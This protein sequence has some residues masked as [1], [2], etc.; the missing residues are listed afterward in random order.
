M[1]YYNLILSVTRNKITL[2]LIYGALRLFTLTD[3]L[4]HFTFLH[5]IAKLKLSLFYTFYASLILHK[6]FHL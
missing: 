2:F 5:N 6:M 3:I 1:Y 4:L